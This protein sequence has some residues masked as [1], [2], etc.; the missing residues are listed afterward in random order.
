MFDA[1]QNRAELTP[2]HPATFSLKKRGS[3]TR[4]SEHAVTQKLSFIL[5]A[6]DSPTNDV[7]NNKAN[8]MVP[9]ALL[10]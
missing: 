10:K 3:P 4:V 6:Y 2:G 8:T 1:I 9:L 7:L 5:I